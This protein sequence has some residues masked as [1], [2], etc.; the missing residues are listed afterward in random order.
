M[1]RMNAIAV[2][3]GLL[4]AGIGGGFELAV[5]GQAAPSMSFCVYWL[6]AGSASQNNP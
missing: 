3:A 2:C 1:G 5:H 6:R 4:L